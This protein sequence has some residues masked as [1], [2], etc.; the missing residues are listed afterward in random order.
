MT[1][2]REIEDGPGTALILDDRQAWSDRTLTAAEV[3]SALRLIP[4][5]GWTAGWTGRRQRAELVLSAMAHLSPEQIAEL[6]VG[7]IAVHDSIASI[8]T[9]TECLEVP[10][11]EETL[12]CGPCALARWVHAL[13]LAVVFSERVV[14]A[15]IARSAPLHA[16][17]P[18]LCQQPLD[19]APPTRRLSLFPG[20]RDIFVGNARPVGDAP[21][22]P[23]TDD[24]RSTDRR[25][26]QTWNQ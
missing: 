18:H 19:I 16:D 10:N 12:L 1:M 8:T 2:L 11:S 15:T 22:D 3:E 20:P 21:H 6:A 7:Q 24:A 26:R 4:S 13:D 17:S 23:S 5:H 25:Y 14:A 9:A